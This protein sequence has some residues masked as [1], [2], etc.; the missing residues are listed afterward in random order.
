LDGEDVKSFNGSAAM[1]HSNSSRSN[2]RATGVLSAGF[3]SVAVGALVFFAANQLTASSSRRPGR[4]SDDTPQ[5]ARR[6][7][8]R[9]VVGRTVTINRPRAELYA[10]WR[11]FAKLPLFMENVRSVDVLDSKRSRWTIAGP[12]GVDAEFVAEIVEEK[13]DELIAWQSE[14]GAGV[15]NSGRITFRDAPGGRGTEVD[16][17]IAYDPPGGTVGQ[18]AAKLMQRE[19]NVQARRELKRFKQLMEAGEIATAEPGPAAPRGK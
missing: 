19:P 8:R 3:L 17:T 13:P 6:R 9:T 16:A 12:G 18:W 7:S 4:Y 2:R 15:R 14:Q 1:H 11:D 10:F 5:K